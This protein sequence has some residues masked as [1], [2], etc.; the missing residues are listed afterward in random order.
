VQVLFCKWDG[1]ICRNV[2]DFISRIVFVVQVLERLAHV[3]A[4]LRDA[5]FLCMVIQSSLTGSNARRLMAG[6]QVPSGSL[7]PSVRL[8]TR[9]A[10]Q[11]GRGIAVCL[12][13]S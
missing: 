1:L 6:L 3:A 9:Q 4:S 11:D 10:G 2:L 13:I 8:C 7:V 5:E 12:T